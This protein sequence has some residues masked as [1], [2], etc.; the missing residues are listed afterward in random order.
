MPLDDP[1]GDFSPFGDD[2][3]EVYRKGGFDTTL[4]M[5]SKTGRYRNQTVK[6]L[7]A[8]VGCTRSTVKSAWDS[9][10]N[11]VSIAATTPVIAYD[12]VTKTRLAVVSEPAKSRINAYPECKDGTGWGAN[13]S[14]TLTNLT[15]NALGA[16]DGVLIE[17]T[18]TIWHGLTVSS[19]TSLTDAAVY[20]V[21]WAFRAGTSGK[22]FLDFYDATNGT[23]TTVSGTVGSLA[24]ST[25]SG[26]TVSGLTQR[27]LSDGVTWL[28]EYYVTKTTTG[29]AGASIT[30]GSTTAGEDITALGSWIGGAGEQLSHCPIL[31]GDGAVRNTAA[32]GLSLVAAGSDPFTGYDQ[33]KN[34]GKITIT[35]NADG[36]LSY[37]SYNDTTSNEVIEVHQ[38]ASNN[39]RL[40][41]T[42][43]GVVQCD[44][45]SLVNAVI[46]TEVTIAWRAGVNDFGISV[47][48]AAE[49]TDAAGTMPTVTQQEIGGL[50]LMAEQ[51]AWAALQSDL[52]GISA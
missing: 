52:A 37:I 43:G 15:L 19:Y 39:I 22:A 4:V 13:G 35:P 8:L 50:G 11:V 3:W 6:N 2:W 38:D 21:A 32:D 42:D 9:S 41:V 23:N 16:L 10:G 18:A 14:P 51:V 49:Q 44:I 24:A 27:L 40:T 45:D 20:P 1:F 33:T 7:S 25:V 34:S 31:G 26:G 30:P 47:D 36:A 28:V 46:G 12:S 17:G 29:S 48:G 5:S